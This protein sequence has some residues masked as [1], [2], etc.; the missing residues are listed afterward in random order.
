MSTDTESPR[1]LVPVPGLRRLTQAQFS[2]VIALLIGVSQML[3]GI[4]ALDGLLTI[5]VGWGG[6]LLSG[7]GSNLIRNRPVFY[8]GWHEDGEPGWFI[9]LGSTLVTATI[10]VAA[11]LVLV[12]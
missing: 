10:V 12:G 2:G 6:G 5:V 4:L 7:F 9:W 1:L 11:G 8:S 3:V